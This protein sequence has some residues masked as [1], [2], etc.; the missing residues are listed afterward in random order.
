MLIPSQWLSSSDPVSRYAVIIS[1][2]IMAMNRQIGH[3][4]S[5]NIHRIHPQR[6]QTL[7]HP[8]SLLFLDLVQDNTANKVLA[9]SP[10]FLRWVVTISRSTKPVF[11]IISDGDRAAAPAPV[12]GGALE[13]GLAWRYL[14]GVIPFHGG[15]V[16]IRS[17]EILIPLTIARTARFTSLRL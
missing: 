12:L 13:P 7:Y 3:N 16:R 6:P 8:V 10:L 4:Q 1:L 9:S 17:N 15:L 2:A 14:S 5:N 11:Y